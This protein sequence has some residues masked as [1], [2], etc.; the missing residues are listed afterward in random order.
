MNY[1]NPSW[2]ALQVRP[3]AEKVVASLLQFKG[4]EEFLPVYRARRR[5]SDRVKEVEV[6]LFP[7]YVFVRFNLLTGPPIVTT[8]GVIRIV[9]HGNLPI[10]IDD[11]EI[12]T[13]KILVRS[14]VAPEPWPFVSVGQRVH[15]ASGPLR[16]MKGIVT[17]LTNRCRIVVSVSLLQRSVA[18]EIDESWVTFDVLD[19]AATSSLRGMSAGS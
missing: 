14:G 7:G 10:A 4:Y 19:S 1:H 6:P 12:S 15:I 11:E 9:G 2:F 3:R 5:W 17:R 13:L 18:A 16:G 8:P